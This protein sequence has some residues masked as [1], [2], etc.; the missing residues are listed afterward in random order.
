MSEI[1]VPLEST[2]EHLEHAAHHAQHE[3][4]KQNWITWSALFSAMLAVLAAIAALRAGHLADEGMVDQ[5][6][7]SDT[8]AFYQAKGIKAS[9]LESRIQLMETL[10]HPLDEASH[11]KLA[12][13]GLQQK[14]LQ[15]KAKEHEAASA[16]SFALHG[17]FAQAVTFFQI[18]IAIT[19]IAVLARRR[20]FLGVAFGF[21]LVGIYFVLKGFL[22]F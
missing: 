16:K 21:G 5:I 20:K 8:W 19:A 10:K 15:E 2:Q 14:E 4:K 18:A 12:E 17:I 11:E 7:A 9:L 1:E 6:K 3:D 13:Y 22:Q